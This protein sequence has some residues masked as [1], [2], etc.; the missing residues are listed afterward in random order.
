MQDKP[1]RV[2]KLG[3]PKGSLQESTFELFR[4]AG[5]DIGITP[6]SSYPSVQDPEIE[7]MLLRAQEISRY[8]AEGVLDAGI[9]GLDWITESGVDL[10]QICELTYSKGSS[11]PVRWV[12][13]VANESPIQELEELEGKLIVSEI[14]NVAKSFLERRGIHARVEFSWGAT[15]AKARL[16]GVAA[17]MELTD[18]EAT[19]RAHNLRVLE[20][21]MESTPRLVASKEAWENPWK[22][23][24]LES[25]S[26]L[27]QGACTALGKVGFKM[28]VA[29][30]NLEAVLALLPAMKRPT[31]S[32]L[33]GEDW[34]AVESVLDEEV[35]KELIPKLKRAGAEGIIEYPLN[36]VIP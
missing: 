6:R 18:T 27:L 31:V 36:K 34:F 20:V 15:E 24:K 33:A 28:N 11:R 22:R 30:E 7:P 17:I 35:V 32:S 3:L 10:V 26:L 21:V 9:T 5:F 16:P 2:L 29:Q 25:L 8:V 23:S 13:A 19:L 4:R 14:V 1:E 12:L